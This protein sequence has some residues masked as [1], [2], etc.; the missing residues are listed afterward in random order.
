M[1]LEIK[2][3]L[4]EDVLNIRHEVLWPDKSP[5]FVKLPEDDKATHF[6][7]F[8]NDQIVSAISLFSCGQNVRFRKFATLETF[9]N[10]GLGSKLLQFVIDDSREQGYEKIW[11]D[12]RSGA[13]GFYEKFGFTKFSDSFMKENIEYIKIEKML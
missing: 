8:F 11:C 13:L 3:V 1:D 7:L 9:Q 5:E 10:K 12:A 2:R 6:G 4:V